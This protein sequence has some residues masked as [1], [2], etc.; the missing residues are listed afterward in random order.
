VLQL[1]EVG[2]QLALLI[3]QAAL[4]LCDLADQHPIVH[5]HEVEVLVAVDQV[6]E[7]LRGEQDLDVREGTS[8]VDVAH[9][10]LQDRAA[11]DEQVLSP[12]QVGGRDADGLLGRRDLE[13]ELAQRVV[14]DVDLLAEVVELCGE[15]VRPRLQ[16]VHRAPQ[17]A[18]LRPDLLETPATVADLVLEVGDLR[19]DVGGEDG[20]DGTGQREGGD[21]RGGSH[22][23]LRCR[24]RAAP[25]ARRPRS[26][27]AATSPPAQAWGSQAMSI[28]E[29]STAT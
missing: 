15:R 14:A 10:A 1:V 27:P 22:S 8:F 5:G 25:L 11:Q 2:A 16:L 24:R 3:D 23:A 29:R 17:L 26:A 28:R 12:D 21:E 20:R 6:G 19:H 9:A 7:A 18:A 13:L 4:Q